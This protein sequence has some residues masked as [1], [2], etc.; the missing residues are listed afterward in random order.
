MNRSKYISILNSPSG[1]FQLYCSSV[2]EVSQ[3]T[4]LHFEHR[5]GLCRAF[6]LIKY[7]LLN[8]LEQPKAANSHRC[9]SVCFVNYKS[10][11]ALV[12][13]RHSQ[14]N[15]TYAIL[16]VE[17]YCIYRYFFHIFLIEIS[18]FE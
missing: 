9:I 17:I 4:R 12:I 1:W 18:C 11:T 2:D 7:R 3:Y 15:V 13:L 6:V 16:K 8:L 14:S 5:P 10:I